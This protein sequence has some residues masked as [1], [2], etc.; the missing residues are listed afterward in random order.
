MTNLTTQQHYDVPGGTLKVI[1]TTDHALSA[2]EREELDHIAAVCQAFQE[3]QR[4]HPM[5]EAVRDGAAAAELD[6]AMW[7]L[8]GEEGISAG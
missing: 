1:L 8:G 5:H 7:E 2:H 3:H 4:S 6:E